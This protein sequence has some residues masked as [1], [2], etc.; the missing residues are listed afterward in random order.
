[1]LGLSKKHADL[2]A[3][4]EIIPILARPAVSSDLLAAIAAR[5]PKVCVIADS[6]GSF[7]VVR[8]GT[9]HSGP[10][11][12]A[13]GGGSFQG[14]TGAAMEGSG[15]S[16]AAAVRACSDGIV[17]NPIMS[18]KVRHAYTHHTEHGANQMLSAA[19]IENFDER[20]SR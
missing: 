8:E 3:D 15:A 11:D 2:L 4:T 1:M 6:G 10:A 9:L 17:S 7:E 19:G 13:N 12:R 18:E 5:N 14:G 20:G 16:A